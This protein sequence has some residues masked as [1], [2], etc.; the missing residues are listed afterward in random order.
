MLPE[1]ASFYMGHKR[2]LTLSRLAQSS[3]I[4]A[5]GDFVNGKTPN[6]SRAVTWLDRILCPK[7]ISV[8][9]IASQPIATQM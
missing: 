1:F 6:K 4:C 7:A 5:I 3:D 2:S 9:A 8:W